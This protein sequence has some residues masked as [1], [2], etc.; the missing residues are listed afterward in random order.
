MLFTTGLLT[1]HLPGKANL[2]NVFLLPP[3]WKTWTRVALG[4]GTV[5]QINKGIDR[6]PPAWLSG[7]ESA[8][9]ITPMALKF[10]KTSLLT[11]LLVAP[12]VT[13]SVQTSQW[14]NKAFT[15]DLKAQ[16]HIPEAVTRLC[17]SFAVSATGILFA[18]LLH[19]K[20]PQIKVF[21]AR[22]FAQ[23]DPKLKEPAG[24]FAMGSCAR[25]CS[26]SI[27]CLSE[28]GEMLGGMGNWLKSHWSPGPQPESQQERR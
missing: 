1:H 10:H 9:V 24:A 13:A 5:Q 7:L 25:G 12:L 19:R 4:I 18:M 28:I 16:W 6:N 15:Q 21:G 27:I 8:A 26:P 2:S 20:A 23:L 14:L 3:D 11:F 17:F 22:P